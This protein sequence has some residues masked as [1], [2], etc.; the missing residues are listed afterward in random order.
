MKEHANSTKSACYQHVIDN[1]DHRMD[2][3]NIQVIDRASSNF[4]A[5]MKELLHILHTKPELN[6]QLNPQSKYEIKM[7]I[8]Q[9]Y[10]QHR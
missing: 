4:K 3:D 8:I 10:P 9:A 7:L 6:K 5:K 1:P 2:Y